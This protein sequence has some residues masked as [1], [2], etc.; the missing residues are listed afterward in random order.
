MCNRNAQCQQL[1][2][3]VFS[4]VL[5]LSIIILYKPP[6]FDAALAGSPSF[7][8]QEIRDNTKGWIDFQTFNKVLIGD[9]STDI[10]KVYYLS[11]GKFLNA[12]L[13]LVAPFKDKPSNKTEILSYGML[14]DADSNYATGVLGIDY[15]VGVTWNNATKSWTKVFDELGSLNEL[16]KVGEKTVVSPM[17]NYTGFFKSGEKYIDLST[18]LSELGSPDNYRIIFYAVEKKQGT[19]LL[20]DFSTWAYVPPPKFELS[21]N[22]DPVEVAQGENHTFTIQVKSTSDNQPLRVEN[23]V[24]KAPSN[25]HLIWDFNALSKSNNS[26]PAPVTV[27]A[28]GEAMAGSY[29]ASVITIMDQYSSFPFSVVEHPNSPIRVVAANGTFSSGHIIA[30]VPLTIKITVTLDLWDNIHNWFVKWGAVVAFFFAIATFLIGLLID[31]D[32]LIKRL[33]RKKGGKGV[34]N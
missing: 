6:F 7:P 2:Y 17:P 27:R 15:R 16:G 1:R 29:T 22:P 12:T 30:E 11:N 21:T 33:Y 20:A 14:I 9:E 5:L 4:S 23:F 18:D 3:V 13:W 26:E 31:K 10:S 32:T 24:G 34:I 8:R 19:P 28:D 25:H